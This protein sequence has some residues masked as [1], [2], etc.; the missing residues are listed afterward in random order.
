MKYPYPSSGG[1]FCLTSLPSGNSKF[2][3]LPSK[4]FGF[5]HPFPLGFP[6]LEPHNNLTFINTLNFSEEVEIKFSGNKAWLENKEYRTQ[7]LVAHG[8]G[9]SKVLWLKC[10]SY[11]Q[12]MGLANMFT[13]PLKCKLPPLVSFLARCLSFFSKPVSFLSRRISFLSRIIEAF[14]MELLLARSWHAYQKQH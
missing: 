7:P 2:A 12:Q 10:I 4:N 1:C 5:L 9:P 8:N 13:V 6:G 14:S 11:I 3:S